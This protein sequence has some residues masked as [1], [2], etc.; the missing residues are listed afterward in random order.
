M[1]KKCLPIAAALAPLLSTESLYADNDLVYVAV[2]P[3]RIAD[4]RKSVQGE[5]VRNGAR[6]FLV[7]GSEDELSGQG[8]QD[9]PHPK[10]DEGVEPVAIAAYYVAVPAPSSSGAGIITAY[11]SDKPK[12]APGTGATLNFDFGQILGNTSITTL[13]DA[14]AKDCP[15]GGPL[16][17]MVR[18]TAEHVVVDVQ[19]YFYPQ[20][21]LP[22][23]V[24][25]EETEFTV[26]SLQLTVSVNCPDG[27]TVV[28]GGGAVADPNWYMFGSAPLGSGSGW[29]VGFRSNGETLS[30][31]GTARAVCADLPR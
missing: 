3:C 4:T 30:A 11:P 8:G 9:C 22:G 7:S 10:A 23:Y 14:N 25:V 16:A 17:I 28:S 6:Q 13:C 24:I 26:N 18:D 1:L 12:P 29:E 2:E 21:A 27:K 15:N 20:T 31:T 5:I 19:G